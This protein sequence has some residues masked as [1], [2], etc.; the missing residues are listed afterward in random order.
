ME[1]TKQPETELEYWV[2]I[3]ELGGFIWRMNHDLADG[4]IEDPTGGGVREVE[5]AQDICK[6]L[7]GELSEKFGVIPP[8]ECPRV[9]LGEAPPPTP[10]G[11][12]Y[13]WDWYRRM[14]EEAYRAEYAGLICSACPFSD[15]VEKMI[16]LGGVIPCG[17]FSGMMYRL[18]APHL[19]GM[20]GPGGLWSQEKLYELMRVRHGADALAAFQQKEAALKPA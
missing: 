8:A 1:L 17:V 10:E 16:A 19:C 2:A 4:R 18:S 11:K 20:T 5:S 14:K 3:E 12:A 15:G 9:A 6:R 7:V 13:Y